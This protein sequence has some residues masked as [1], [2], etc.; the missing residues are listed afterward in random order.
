MTKS[1]FVLDK[2][3]KFLEEG[4]V[5]YK[6][7]TNEVLNI[8]KSKREEVIFRMKLTS[9][10]ETEIIKKRV[11]NLEKKLKFL[12]RKKLLKKL[13]G[14][15]NYNSQ[16]TQRRFTKLNIPSMGFYNVR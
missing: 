10:E 6:D 11:E 8:L 3:S 12:K 7:L 5:N 16:T 1:R 4:I 13:R 14:Q 9:K 2:L 15:R